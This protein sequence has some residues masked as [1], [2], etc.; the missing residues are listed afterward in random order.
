MQAL[1]G[2]G[3]PNENR[4]CLCDTV[5]ARDYSLVR[6]KGSQAAHLCMIL[7]AI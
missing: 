5:Y 6:I 4:T 2:M 1:E 3:E 7:A